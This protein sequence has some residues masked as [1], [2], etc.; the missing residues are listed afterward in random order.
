MK[1]SMTLVLILASV[2]SIAF[3][4]DWYHDRDE[5]YRG[6]QWRPHVFSH[7]RQDLDHIW[8]ARNA[9]EKE[10]ARL[11]KTKE[12]LAQMQADL[13]QGR[14]DN[15]LLNDAIDSLKKSANDDRLSPRDRAVL[16]DDVNRL[17]DYQAN[18]N[19]WTH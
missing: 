2:T 18:H 9:S 17:H 7:V 19:H 14:F 3:A 1:Q 4:Q 8:S 15:G 12:E 6:D 11:A 10:N 16:A 13:D 5:R